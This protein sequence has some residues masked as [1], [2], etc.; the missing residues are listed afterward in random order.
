MTLFNEREMKSNDMKKS[1]QHTPFWCNIGVLQT[2]V[3]LVALVP[4][5]SRVFLY[6]IPINKSVMRINTMKMRIWAIKEIK[7]NLLMNIV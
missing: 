7:I 4:K 3:R 5:R 1:L 6:G 2:I